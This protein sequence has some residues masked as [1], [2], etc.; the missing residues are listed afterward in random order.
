MKPEHIW[1]PD[2]LPS[3][4]RVYLRRL[5]S[6]GAGPVVAS[7]RCAC[8]GPYEVYVNGELAARSPGSALTGCPMWEEHALDGLLRT[9]A[10][11]VLAVAGGSRAGTAQWFV[12]EGHASGVDGERVDLSTGNGWTA[13]RA[14]TWQTYDLGL[15]SGAYLASCEPA[16]WEQGAFRPTDWVPAARVS[17]PEPSP[18]APRAAAAAEVWAERLDSFGEV[19]LAAGML[20]SARPSPMANG[21]CV[22]PEAVL[23]PGRQAALVQTR[24]P[25]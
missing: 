3:Y 12:A 7:V 13:Q 9:G 11:V 15:L 5:F 4:P 2:P 18:W 19:D 25:E 1:H 24:A 17:G 22:R 21:K 20:F 8:C 23:T 14:E 16:A 6:L 10:N